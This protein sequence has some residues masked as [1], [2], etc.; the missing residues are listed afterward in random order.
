M[1]VPEEQEEEPTSVGQMEIPA[2]EVEG[3]KDEAEQV[4][5]G[6]AQ[7]VLVMVFEG[8][9]AMVF[10]GALAMVLEGALVMVLEGA[11]VM[12]FGAVLVVALEGAWIVLMQKQAELVLGFVVQL[13]G[14]A[15]SL[16]R[17]SLLR[18]YYAGS[19]G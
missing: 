12:T 7:A 11:L 5:I 15:E 6:Y 14:V 3:K 17:L 16:W 18:V 10:E 4:E 1:M 8:A 19:L 9:L 13:A 2:Y